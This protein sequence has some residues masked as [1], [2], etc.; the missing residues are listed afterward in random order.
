MIDEARARHRLYALLGEL[1]GVGPVPDAVDIARQLSLPMPGDAD[2]LAAGHQG[3]VVGALPWESAWCSPDAQ[4]GGDPAEA[5]RAAYAEGGFR[6]AARHEPDHLGLELAYLAHLCAAEAEALADEV[7]PEPILTLQRSFVDRHV[8]RWLP[9]YL[10]AVQDQRDPAWTPI[11]ELAAE[12]VA[13]QGEVSPWT[14]P[15]GLPDLSDPKL[16]LA[17]VARALVTPARSGWMPGPG[18][19]ARLGEAAEVPSGFGDRVGRMLTLLRSAGTAGTLDRLGSA[20]DADLARWEAELDGTAWA[21]AC[22]T[23]RA[24]VAE[25]VAMP[26]RTE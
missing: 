12:L 22:R 10:L 6:P 2:T 3:A 15:G 23:T 5:V 9:A 19:F 7:D 21:R 26:S 1:I 13:S 24:W 25:M 18:T 11:V 16:G 20:I 14:L 8:G 17:G 4:L